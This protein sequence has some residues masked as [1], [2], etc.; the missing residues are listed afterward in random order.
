MK[1][2]ILII[3]VGGSVAAG[4]FLVSL[5]PLSFAIGLIA[6]V[7]LSGLAIIQHALRNAPEGYEDE[8]G[9]HAKESRPR[10][11]HSVWLRPASSP[12]P[13]LKIGPA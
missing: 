13:W 7:A 9:F 12:H 6:A 3:T 5:C 1:A 11:H 2:I 8:E 4:G 10:I